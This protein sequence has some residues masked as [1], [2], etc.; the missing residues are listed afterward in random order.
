MALQAGEMR[1]HRMACI[2]LWMAGGPSQ[3]ETFDPKPG[4]A[5]GGETKAIETAVPGI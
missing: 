3:I 4:T 1:K 5:H 2:L